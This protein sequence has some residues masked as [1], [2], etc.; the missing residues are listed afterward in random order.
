MEALCLCG[1]LKCQTSYSR[2]RD[3]FAKRKEQSSVKAIGYRQRLL[4]AS[5]GN[6][7]RTLYDMIIFAL[8]M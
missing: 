4:T 8:H 6:F 2:L 7:Q 5:V 3:G 1:S